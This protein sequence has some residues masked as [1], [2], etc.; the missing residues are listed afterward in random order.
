MHTPRRLSPTTA[1]AYLAL[2]I[3][4][5][6]AALALEAG[7]ALALSRTPG[8]D[9]AASTTRKLTASNL[10][11]SAR[12]MPAEGIFVDCQLSTALSA[13]EQDL[14]QVHAAGMQVA[15]ASMQGDT[16]AELAAYAA[17]AQSVGVSLMWQINDPGF[18]GGTWVGAS[19]A[20]D[21]SQFS[22]ACGC[23]STS[24][25]LQYMIQWLAA[26]PA[27]YGYYAA[28]DSTL[29]PEQLQGLT[30]YVSA[31]RAADPNHMI[32]VGSSEGQGTTYYP[33][34]A[35]IGNEIYPETTSSLMPYAPNSPTWQAVQQG[36]QQDARA[37][38]GTGTASAFILQAF[39]F[40][41]N[42]WDGEAV[43]VCTASMSQAQCASLL[44]YP[45]EAVQL[46]LR[47]EV[48]LH[49]DPKLIL[50]FNYGE[51]TQGNRWAGLSRVVQAPYP[52]TASAARAS[53]LRAHTQRR[54]LLE[55]RM[56]R[57]RHGHA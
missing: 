23:S 3:L 37:A 46:E 19:A 31:I 52:V 11:R 20:A 57:R 38:A 40:G 17:Y 22:A 33:S 13:C 45:S 34:G 8:P 43:G 4:I 30:Q 55:Q 42:I 50:W 41:D 6:S 24:Q 14:A 10:P 16:L 5:L 26:L 54:L 21:W 53:K 51:A 7:N 18:W 39:S 35:T 32:M 9:A 36:V 1:L 25:V 29:T 48:L 12:A 56:I 28:D 27:T 2:L 47:N 44:E 49:A 15:V